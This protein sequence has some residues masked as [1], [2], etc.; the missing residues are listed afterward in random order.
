MTRTMLALLPKKLILPVAAGLAAFTLGFAP[1]PTTKPFRA[2]FDTTFDSVVTFPIANISVVGAGQA[3]HMGATAAVTTNQTVNFITGQGTATYELT[4]ANGDTVILEL[5]AATTFLPNGVTF[6]GT[7]VITSGTG[8][9]DGAGGAGS[10][11]GT[12]TFT[13]PTNGFG[14]FAVDGTLTQ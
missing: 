11:F 10:I 4:A 14:T 2:T 8:R 6:A 9:F 1:A 13:G 7:Y 5:D 3:L 12:A